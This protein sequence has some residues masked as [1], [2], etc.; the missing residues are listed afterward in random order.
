MQ[1]GKENKNLSRNVG[2]G[3]YGKKWRGYENCVNE[4]ALAENK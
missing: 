3:A 4:E 1:V 2:Y